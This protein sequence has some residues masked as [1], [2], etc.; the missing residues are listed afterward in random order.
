MSEKIVQL[1]K[2]VIKGQLK[3]RPGAE[4]DCQEGGGWHRRNL[5]LLR[6]SQ[7]TLDSHPHQQCY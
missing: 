2:K 4:G 7:R 6:V 5:D 3:E 1:N